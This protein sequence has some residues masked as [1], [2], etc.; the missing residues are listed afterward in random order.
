MKAFIGRLMCSLAGGG[1]V[2]AVAVEEVEALLVLL[3]PASL[4]FLPRS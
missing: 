4:S 1:K 3:L 2:G